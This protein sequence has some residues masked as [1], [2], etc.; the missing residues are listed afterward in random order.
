MRAGEE[1]L[2]IL[3]QVSNHLFAS[4]EQLFS[5]LAET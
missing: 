3:E 5:I 2:S 1:F 4:D